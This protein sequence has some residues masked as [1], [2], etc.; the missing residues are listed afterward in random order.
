M[1]TSFRQWQPVAPG[2]FELWNWQFVW[3]F[4][5]EE[6]AQRDYVGGQ[7]C[8]GSAG[9]YEQDDTVAWEASSV[10]RRARGCAR[11]A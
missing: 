4:Q 2:K 3:N 8:F 7:Y 9:V 6:S 10:P 1:F 5:D 11:K